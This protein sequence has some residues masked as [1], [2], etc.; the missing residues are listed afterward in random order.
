M[1]TATDPQRQS[2]PHYLLS[3]APEAFVPRLRKVTVHYTDWGFDDVFDQCRLFPMPNQVTHLELRYAFSNA[4]FQKLAD[5]AR[6][7]YDAAPQWASV[8]WSM[9]HI[10]H[11]TVSGA[12][13][14]FVSAVAEMCPALETLEVDRYVEMDRKWTV[15][16]GVKTLIL[17]DG[18]LLPE[19]PAV[20]WWDIAKVVGGNPCIASNTMEVI[21]AGSWEQL[22]GRQRLK[23]ACLREG[24]EIECL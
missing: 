1:Q 2:L 3:L 8:R 23:R 24:I 9:E 5:R 15:P 6:E 20:D 22:I 14:R 12:P 13:P 19:N 17:L 7:F 4:P 16:N 11:L 10:T 18:L 21:L